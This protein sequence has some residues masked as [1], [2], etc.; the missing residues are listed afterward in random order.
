MDLFILKYFLFFSLRTYNETFFT[1]MYMNIYIYIFVCV[2][3][4]NPPFMYAD[5]ST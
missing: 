3:R 2:Q 5:V 4:L 1:Y